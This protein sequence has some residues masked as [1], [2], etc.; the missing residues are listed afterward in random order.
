MCKMALAL[1]AT[2]AM[3]LAGSADLKA[4]LAS[5]ATAVRNNSPIENVNCPGLR[6]RDLC[7]VGFYWACTLDRRCVCTSCFAF[8]RYPN[9]Y[10][11]YRWGY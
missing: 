9:G 10:Y 2:V 11:W 1:G 4:E 5:P 7:P 6:R 8:R 3:M